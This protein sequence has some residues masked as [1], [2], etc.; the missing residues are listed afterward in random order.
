MRSVASRIERL[1]DATVQLRYAAERLPY[2]IGRLPYTTV[3]VPDR[4]AP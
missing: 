3:P 2:A 4:G 1:P